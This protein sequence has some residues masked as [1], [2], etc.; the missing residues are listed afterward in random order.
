MTVLQDPEVLDAFERSSL[1]HLDPG[2]I[3]RL[4]MGAQVRDVAAG[5]MLHREEDPPF[6]DLVVRGMI[7]AYVSAPNGRTRTIRYF[8]SGALI[9]TGT[10]FNET[11]P[12]G[13]VQLAAVLTSRL[14]VLQPSVV[15]VRAQEETA[16]A[17]ALLLETSA[18]VGD[19]INELEASSF[20]SVRQRLARHLLDLASEQ[21]VGPELMARASQEELAG[22]VGTVREIVVRTLRDMRAEGLVRTARGAVVLLDPARLEANTFAP[23]TAGYV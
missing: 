11:R 2:A 17:L 18:R 5:T 8:R 3:G 21:Q 9:G 10:V 12:R 22:A 23:E 19:Y 20:A 15:R 13:R 6:C 16:L 14:L 4:A 1:R 7:R